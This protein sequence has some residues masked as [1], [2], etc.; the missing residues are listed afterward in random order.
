M[1]GSI[2]NIFFI[3][4]VPVN[5]VLKAP[6]RVCTKF[7]RRLLPEVHNG[8]PEDLA[9]RAEERKRYFP[10]LILSVCSKLNPC[11]PVSGPEI[12]C[13]LTSLTSKF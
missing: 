12:Y 11:H 4:T 10:A 8:F 3:E 2:V 1:L 6:Y 5:T 9:H 7:Y 13:V